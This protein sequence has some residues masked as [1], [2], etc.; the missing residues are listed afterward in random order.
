MIQFDIS[1]Q[2]TTP[3]PKHMNMEQTSVVALANPTPHLRAH[4]VWIP[5]TITL[6]E[7]IPSAS[8]SP[9]TETSA[10]TITLVHPDGTRVEL[11]SGNGTN[12]FTGTT[13]DDEAGTD[14]TAGS[15]P[16]T[17][18]YRP[19]EMLSALD[20]KSATGLWQLEISGNA[21]VPGTLNA[22]SLDITAL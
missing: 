19:E 15:S 18:S 13:F 14:V 20:G 11:T 10:M 9:N 21:I 7:L 17:G 8:T 2:Y 3:S 12:D 4:F 5:N 22:W 6:R 16:F 1:D